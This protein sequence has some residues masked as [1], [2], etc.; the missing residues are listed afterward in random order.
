MKSKVI[1]ISAISAGLIAMILS[2]GVYF[3]VADIS[4]VIL[5][6]VVVLLPLYYKSYLGG[7][8][9]YLAGGL[10]AFLITGFNFLSIV[11]ISYFIFFGLFPII[12]I[13][14]ESKKLNKF[15]ILAIGVIWCVLSCYAVYFYYTMVM[16]MPLDSL[17]EFIKNYVLLFIFLIGVVFF[18][19]YDFFINV[20]RKLTE[21][22]LRKILK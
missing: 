10:I 2:F 18:A 16:C 9:S 12:K 17:P 11:F 19:V 15:L 4:A 13:L 21:Y 3:Q 22:Y 6:S 1:A 14:L 20:S 7:F 8:L 5:S